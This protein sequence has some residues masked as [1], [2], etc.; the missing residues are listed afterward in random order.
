MRK[1]KTNKPVKKRKMKKKIIAAV[2]IVIALVIIIVPTVIFRNKKADFKVS[3]AIV[4]SYEVVK[5]NVS[6]TIRNFD[7]NC[8]CYSWIWCFNRRGACSY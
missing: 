6:T 5:G 2:C 7:I 1:N 8:I 3:A 4:K